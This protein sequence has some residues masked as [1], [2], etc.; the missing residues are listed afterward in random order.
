MLK[1]K[2]KLEYT[3][4]MV[5]EIVNKIINDIKDIIRDIGGDAYIVGGYIRDKLLQKIRNL[6]IWI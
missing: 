2:Y 6:R 5:G 1:L 4:I 3:I